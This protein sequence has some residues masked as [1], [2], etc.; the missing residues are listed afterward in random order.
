[1]KNNNGFWTWQKESLC[2]V[3]VGLTGV[4][5]TSIRQLGQLLL[6]LERLQGSR[7]VPTRVAIWEAAKRSREPERVNANGFSHGRSSVSSVR[8][9]LASERS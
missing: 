7:A 6:C 8:G 5:V 9:T 1:M 3:L 4:L 2:W